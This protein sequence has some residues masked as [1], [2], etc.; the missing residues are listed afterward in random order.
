M[1][2]RALICDLD[3]TIANLA[4][5]LHHIKNGNKNW[6]GFFENVEAD[7][8]IWTTLRALEGLH[9]STGSALFVV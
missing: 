8:P 2:K 9:E 5:R 4:H 7:T 1:T 6:E 3:G